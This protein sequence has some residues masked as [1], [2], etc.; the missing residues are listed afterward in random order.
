MGCYEVSL[1]DTLGVGSPAQVHNLITYLISNGVP[2]ERLAGHFHDTYGQALANIWESYN[3]GLRTFDSSISGL[4]GCPF[5]PGAQGNVSTED[6][7]YMFETAGIKT[8]V[9][10]ESLSGTGHW[11]SSHLSKPSASRAGNAIATSIRAKQSASGSPRHDNVEA[12]S[13]TP[14]KQTDGLL[15]H[16]SGVNLMITMNRPKNGNALTTTMILD[17][18]GIFKDIADDPSVHRI[19]LTGTGKFFCTGMD[20]GRGS[21][22]VGGE[23]ST[24][25]IQLQRLSQLF[26]AIDNSPKVTI[27]ALNGPAFGGGLG[28]VFASDLRL[29]V[30]SAHITMSEV[31]LGLCPATISKYIIR[32]WGPSFAREAMLTGRPIAP[33]ELF[34]KGI[35]LQVVET[36]EELS[37]TLDAFLVSLRAASS[38][39]SKMCKDLIR[40]GW[41]YGGQDHQTKVIH[42]LFYEMMKP[43][44]PGAYGVKKL[45]K[46]EKIDWDTYSPQRMNKL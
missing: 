15:L 23:G 42:R 14:E 40:V 3:C 4:G 19:I 13:W 30:K 7:V 12:P 41:A 16:R 9:D 38:D 33:S 2:V 26:E 10:I 36:P 21:T 28:L 44:G 22:A 18:T 6:V 11:I 35:I 20:L 32:E 45:Q 29:S 5:A 46:K 37:D 39:A 43:G 25:D 24:A 17:L 34:Q 31:K 1:G 27:A 8:G